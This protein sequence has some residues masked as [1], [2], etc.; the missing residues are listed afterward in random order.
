MIVDDRHAFGCGQVGPCPSVRSGACTRLELAHEFADRSRLVELGVVPGVEDL[1]EDPLRPAVVAG[2]GGGDAAARVVGEAQPAQLAA[3]VGDVELGG[4]ARVL[5]GLDGVLLGGQAESVETHRVQ[6]VVP[7][8]ALEAGVDVGADEAQRV[9]DVQARPGRVR[10][11]VEHEQLLAAL[12]HQLRVSQGAGRVGCLEGVVGVPPVLPAQLDV[13]GEGS[14]VPERGSVAGGVGCLLAG[15]H[16][17]RSAYGTNPRQL[18]CDV[19]G[20]TDRVRLASNGREGI[21]AETAADRARC[22]RRRRDVALRNGA[23]VQL[24]GCD[25]ARHARRSR[26]GRGGRGQRRAS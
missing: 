8:H 21:G 1:V 16:T 6:H 26:G 2:V 7:G 3:V 23:G 20:G 25:R 13:L 22:R 18:R 17:G 15:A 11:H 4:D 9:A 19:L 24:R 14:R 10:E 12:G 5:P